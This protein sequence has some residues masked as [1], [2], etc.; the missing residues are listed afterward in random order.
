MIIV[1]IIAAAGFTIPK[2]SSRAITTPA[3][4]A[5]CMEVLSPVTF[6]K[7]KIQKIPYSEVYPDGYE[8]MQRR[9]PDTSK[10]SRVTGWKAS[11]SL[12]DSL[13]EIVESLSN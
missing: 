6:T 7:S 1:P 2:S 8:D 13:R 11:K 5:D 10:I 12:D 4:T 3:G 9:V